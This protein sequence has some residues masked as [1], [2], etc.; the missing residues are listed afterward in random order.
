MRLTVTD[1]S[2]YSILP[3]EVTTVILLPRHL[4]TISATPRIQ[5]RLL[6]AIIKVDKFLP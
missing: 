3:L 5:L 2:C 6:N 1:G 4:S